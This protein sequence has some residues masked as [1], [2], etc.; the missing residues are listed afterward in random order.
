[1]SSMNRRH[2]LSLLGA[3]AAATSL[4]AFGSPAAPAPESFRFIFL[5]DTHLQPELNGVVGT[6]MAMKHARTLRAD[7]AIQGGDHIF[8]S[9]GTPKP[10][11]L[12][13]FSLYDKT[14]DDLGL[15]VHHTLG[16]HDVCGVYTAAGVPPT[17]PLYGKKLFADRFGPTWYSFDHK[18]VHFMVLDSIG[19]TDDHHYEARID[20]D[21]LAWIAKD[22]AAT[23]PAM[24]IIVTTHIPLASAI[25]SYTDPAPIAAKGTAFTNGPETIKLFEG[26]NVIAVLQGHT[27]VNEEVLW[28]GVP[29][30][31]SGA[32]CGNWWK[33][34]RLG[35]PE[36]F[37]V[38]SVDNGKATTHYETYGFQSIAPQNT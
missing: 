33:G 30:I 25:N 16:N 19:I 18:G 21:Q 5:T 38:V 22:L 1:M 23:P 34:T 11:V 7:F 2:F 3:S 6:D 17:D 31:T 20:P 37:T 28:H 8:D 32:V 24:P 26:H 14:Q 29:Y 36:G 13:N 12:Q 10:T 15:K 4:P 35:T 9:L 27:H